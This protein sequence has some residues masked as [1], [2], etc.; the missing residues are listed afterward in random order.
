MKHPKLSVDK[1]RCSGELSYPPI[2]LSIFELHNEVNRCGTYAVS[3]VVS[4]ARGKYRWRQ[5]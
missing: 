4:D 2:I 3:Q 5:V 1:H